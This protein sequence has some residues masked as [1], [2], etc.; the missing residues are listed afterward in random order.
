MCTLA[1]SLR[2]KIINTNLMF[3]HS[4][5]LGLIKLSTGLMKATGQEIITVIL[6]EKGKWL[7]CVV[8]S[9]CLI[10]RWQ[11]PISNHF[12]LMNYA[13]KIIYFPMKIPVK[14]KLHNPLSLNN[15]TIT[16]KRL[17]SVKQ[18]TQ[19]IIER[20][21]SEVRIILYTQLHFR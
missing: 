17:H 13:R 11:N 19:N 2:D 3:M 1:W 21:F 5:S 18:V 20:A 8:F 12:I 7:G 4:S 9:T 14:I 6:T 16:D 15:F 10:Q